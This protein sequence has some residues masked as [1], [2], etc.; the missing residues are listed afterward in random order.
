VPVGG[1]QSQD[2]G[3]EPIEIVQP[4]FESTAGLRSDLDDVLSEDHVFLPDHRG[5]VGR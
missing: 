4:L 5:I 2:F 1:D 3:G